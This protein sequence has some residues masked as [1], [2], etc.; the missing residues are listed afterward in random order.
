MSEHSIT[1]AGSRLGELIDRA[2]AGEGVVITRNGRPVA[3]LRP[4]MTAVLP[5]TKTRLDLDWLRARRVGAA[6]A[7]EAADLAVS[8]MRDDENDK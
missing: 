8:R 4:L 7:E 1:E 3:E 6:V 2:L 5:T